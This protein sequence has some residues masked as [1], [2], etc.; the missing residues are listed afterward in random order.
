M[1]LC[2]YLR[3]SGEVIEAQAA[4]AFRLH[5]AGAQLAMGGVSRVA[6]AEYA[7]AD[8]AVVAGDGRTGVEN[9]VQPL[10]TSRESAAMPAS[11]FRGGRNVQSYIKVRKLLIWLST[12][13]WK[14]SE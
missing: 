7:L 2:A 8:G 13:L 14:G 4:D 5:A 3:D 6:V 11:V 1:D 12:W 9:G 10:F